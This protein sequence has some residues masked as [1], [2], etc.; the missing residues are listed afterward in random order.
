M[1]VALFVLNGSI[2]GRVSDGI[3]FVPILGIGIVLFQPLRQ[4]LLRLGMV[5]ATNVVD[6]G[7]HVS[8]IGARPVTQIHRNT[9]AQAGDRTDRRWIEADR[10]M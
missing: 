5:Y 4:N 7:R 10:R 2:P 3:L 6:E 1:S 8:D 9:G